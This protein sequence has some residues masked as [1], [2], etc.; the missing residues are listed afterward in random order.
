VGIH[1]V[2]LCVPSTV[3]VLRRGLDA[4]RPV[5]HS[6]AERGNDQRVGTISDQGA[7]YCPE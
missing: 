4:E 1:P 2:T 3:Q 5:M 7:D 6:H